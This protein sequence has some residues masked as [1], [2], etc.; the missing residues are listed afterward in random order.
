MNSDFNVAVHGL[1]YLSHH[2]GTLSSELLA[3]N[4]CTNPARV[5]KVMS[6]L[7]RA[8]IIRTKEGLEG[9]YQLARPAG[10]ITLEQISRALDVEFVRTGW[11]SGDPCKTCLIAAGMGEAM[12]ALYARLDGLCKDYLTG[13]TVQSVAEHIFGK[14]RSGGEDPCRLSGE[15]NTKKEN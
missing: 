8:G 12:D 7:G 2:E 4:I 14:A 6:R 15:N 13:V 5:R 1:V 3:R 11:K 9:G 10:E